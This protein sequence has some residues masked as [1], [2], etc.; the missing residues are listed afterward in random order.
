M[1]NYETKFLASYLLLVYLLL[2][3]NS[4]LRLSVLITFFFFFFLPGVVLYAFHKGR[5]I[6]NSQIVPA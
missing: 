2:N 3:K 4:S 1:F 5:N 6:R